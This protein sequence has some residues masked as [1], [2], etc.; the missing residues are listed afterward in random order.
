LGILRWSQCLVPTSVL[1]VFYS[2]RSRADF[3]SILRFAF[4]R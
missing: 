1:F 3:E 4:L 2:L